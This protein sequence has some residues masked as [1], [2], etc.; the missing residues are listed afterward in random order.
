[1]VLDRQIYLEY[2]P[3]SFLKSSVCGEAREGTNLLFG[4]APWSKLFVVPVVF[5]F[6]TRE[7]ASSLERDEV[8]SLF[9]HFFL[10]S[11]HL[12]LDISKFFKV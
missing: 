4:E 5:S 6:P 2:S 7:H 11:Y 10:Q 9:L 3:I 8:G 1:M 12:W